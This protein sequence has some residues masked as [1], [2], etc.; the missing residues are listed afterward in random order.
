[1]GSP[2]S[3]GTG[4]DDPLREI[5]HRILARYLNVQPGGFVFELGDKPRPI[6]EAR[7]LGHGGARTLY[8]NR[9]PECRSL[10]GIESLTHR[11][12][13]C[14]QCPFKPQCTPQIS[15]DLSVESRPY[16]LLLAHT[17]ASNFLAYDAGIRRQR[18][19]PEKVLHRIEVLDRGSWG[20]L[21]FRCSS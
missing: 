8:R 20:E 14:D 12:R 11:G 15:L 2:L 13:R 9:R 6:I 5:L 16:R 1:M 3:R 18:S 17:S 7:I 21:R 4:G 10:N 19:V